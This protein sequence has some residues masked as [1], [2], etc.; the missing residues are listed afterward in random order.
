M[1]Y[2]GP[3]LRSDAEEAQQ[4]IISTIRKLIEFGEIC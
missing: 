4:K 2:M 1:D 3:I